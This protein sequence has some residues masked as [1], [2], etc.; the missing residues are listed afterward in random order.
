MAVNMCM[1]TTTELLQQRAW[2][3]S[4]VAAP[5]NCREWDYTQTPTPDS[6]SVWEIVHHQP[7]AYTVVAALDPTIEYYAI[8]PWIE[9]LPWETFYA[10]DA[11][12]RCRARVQ[13][14]GVDLE[15]HTAHTTLIHSTTIL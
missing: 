10:Q 4:T 5:E 8:V 9:C 1:Y 2:Q 7:G 14:L 6:V 13:Q 3:P 12:E 11:S 15:T